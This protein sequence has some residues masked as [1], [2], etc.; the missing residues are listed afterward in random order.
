MKIQPNGYQISIKQLCSFKLN[1][2]W[3]KNTNETEL[4]VESFMYILNSSMT[5][6]PVGNQSFRLRKLIGRSTYLPIFF[7][8]YQYTCH[9]DASIHT[10]LVGLKWKQSIEI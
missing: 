9:V 3:R 1:I 4:L 6:T 7:E 2:V 10:Q 5:L 8:G